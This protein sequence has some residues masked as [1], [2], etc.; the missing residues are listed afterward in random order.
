MAAA[1]AAILWRMDT[2]APK[3]AGAGRP[4]PVRPRVRPVPGARAVD[5]AS[6][7]SL[8]YTAGGH[9]VH[10]NIPPFSLLGNGLLWGTCWVI[11][12][13]Y[14]VVSWHRGG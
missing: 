12:G 10:D 4:A 3:A 11:A 14:A 2:A 9:D 1:T 13:L 8:A 6:R 7:A 5:T